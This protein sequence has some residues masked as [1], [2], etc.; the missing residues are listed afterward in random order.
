MLLVTQVLVLSRNDTERNATVSITTAFVTNNPDQPH[1]AATF[2]VA[3]KK[4][5]PGLRLSDWL[6]SEA[7]PGGWP[8]AADGNTDGAGAGAAKGAGG[9]DGPDIVAVGFQEIVPLNAGNVMGGAR[10]R[11]QG[12]IMVP[13]G[14][15][16]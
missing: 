1:Q 8:K 5:P 9:S 6:G 15:R 11:G 16:C 14:R 2:N 10:A 3:G 4:P 12:G 13:A 7:L